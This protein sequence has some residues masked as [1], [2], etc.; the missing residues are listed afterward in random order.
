MKRIV[1]A[2]MS[3][4]ALSAANATIRVVNN[5]N[6]SPG[7]YSDLQVAINAANAGDSIYVTG[8]QIYI[9]ALL[10]LLKK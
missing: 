4:F 2:V 8:P 7:Q 5:N 1:L 9:P 6:P 3:L 10:V